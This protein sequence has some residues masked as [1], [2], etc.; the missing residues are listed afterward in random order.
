MI[1]GRRYSWEGQH[2]SMIEEKT[3]AAEV[4]KFLCVQAGEFEGFITELF[5]KRETRAQFGRR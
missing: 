2:V 4:I 3:L 1:H 5:P